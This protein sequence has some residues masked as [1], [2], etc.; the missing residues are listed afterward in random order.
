MTSRINTRASTDNGGGGVGVLNRTG[1]YKW[2]ACLKK[3]ERGRERGRAKRIQQQKYASTPSK[4]PRGG[5]TIVL[6]RDAGEGSWLTGRPA[7]ARSQV[8][9]KLFPGC[10]SVFIYHRSRPIQLPEG[11]EGGRNGGGRWWTIVTPAQAN[12]YRGAATLH[13]CEKC[14]VSN[15]FGCVSGSTF[16]VRV[17]ETRAGV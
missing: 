6:F 5:L 3:R 7:V 1:G 15:G 2:V 14:C 12:G 11:D 9:S 8:Q 4:A 10:R 16:T 17:R 13:S